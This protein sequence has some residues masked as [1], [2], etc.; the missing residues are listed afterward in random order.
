M[1]IKD[2]IS[3][4]NNEHI[5]LQKL[6]KEKPIDPSTL[7]ET[8]INKLTREGSGS[9]VISKIALLKSSLFHQ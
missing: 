8:L 3:D 9:R 7:L 6:Q 4:I 5:Q 1:F 2:Y